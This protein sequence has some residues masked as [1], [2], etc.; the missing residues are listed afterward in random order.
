MK[1]DQLLQVFD[2]AVGGPVRR[3]SK[4]SVVKPGNESMN[5]FPLHLTPYY[6]YNSGYVIELI[7]DLI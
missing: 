1:V 3:D 4:H 7:E 5:L 6:H 2:A